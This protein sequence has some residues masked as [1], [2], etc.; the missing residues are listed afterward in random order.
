M[1]KK[2]RKKLDNYYLRKY[3][4]SYDQREGMY[5]LQNGRCAICERPESDF[6]KRLAV[7]HNHKSGKV[8]GLLCFRCNKFTVGRHNLESATKLYMYMQRFDG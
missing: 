2:E 1:T 3:G 5:N 6:S 4:I 7:D 8:R